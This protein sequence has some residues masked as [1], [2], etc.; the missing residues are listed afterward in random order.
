MPRKSKASIIPSGDKRKLKYYNQ[1]LKKHEFWDNQP[2]L[3]DD[4]KQ[5]QH[6]SIEGLRKVEEVR[7]ERYDLPQGLVWSDI[8]V[9]DDKNLE[10][11]SYYLFSSTNC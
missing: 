8:D 2:T 9:K 5:V 6:G 11:V 7:K 10:E 1:L 4:M 3:R